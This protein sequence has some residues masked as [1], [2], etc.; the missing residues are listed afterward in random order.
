MELA[1]FGDTE[2]KASE[3]KATWTKLC[4]DPKK[5][6]EEFGR[7]AHIVDDRKALSVG[8]FSHFLPNRAD[9]KI[10]NL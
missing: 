5:I 1:Q 4:S 6:D 9:D 10:F 7:L 2:I 8:K 3:M